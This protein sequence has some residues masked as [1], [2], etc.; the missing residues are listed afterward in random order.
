MDDS[1]KTS[2]Y[3]YLCIILLTIIVFSACSAIVT[4]G[5]E[6]VCYK[7]PRGLKPIGVDGLN[8]VAYVDGYNDVH[9]YTS[10]T[11]KNCD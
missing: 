8:T 5:S 10:Y 6:T 11:L 1:R 3:K 4:G 2:M 7:T 9:I